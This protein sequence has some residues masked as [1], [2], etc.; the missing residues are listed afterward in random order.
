MVEVNM[1]N[2]IVAVL[3]E[4]EDLSRQIKILRRENDALREPQETSRLRAIELEKELA[5]TLADL[6]KSVAKN[7]V[8]R[9][10]IREL[11]LHTISAYFHGRGV[12]HVSFIQAFLVSVGWDFD[13]WVKEEKR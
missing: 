5:W 9:E 1:A 2:S 12:I 8:W 3:K 10:S 7:K 13:E 4:N 6:E 11:A